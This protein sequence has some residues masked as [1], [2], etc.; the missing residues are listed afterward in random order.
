MVLCIQ[1]G[2]IVHAVYYVHYNNIIIVIIIKLKYSFDSNLVEIIYTPN[3]CKSIQ[4]HHVFCTST[5]SAFNRPFLSSVTSDA[6]VAV[7]LLR[8]MKRTLRI[9]E[10]SITS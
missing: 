6:Y 2:H 5:S 1:C 8:H 10:V 4:G 9:I 7:F 3:I